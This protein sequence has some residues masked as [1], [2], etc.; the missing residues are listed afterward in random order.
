MSDNV[1]DYTTGYSQGFRDGWEAAMNTLNT[2]PQW[3]QPKESG[4]PVC[5][6]TGVM[7][8]VCNNPKCPTRI[9]C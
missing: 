8:Y 2:R 4:C 5:G 6:M 7:G 3:T 9:T 1:K